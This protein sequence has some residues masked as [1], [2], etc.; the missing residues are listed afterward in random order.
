MGREEDGMAWQDLIDLIDRQRWLD[1]VGDGL[2]QA[3][4]GLFA[5]AGPRTPTS[6]NT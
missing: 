6:S 2:Q 5:A 1:P 3:V 4:G